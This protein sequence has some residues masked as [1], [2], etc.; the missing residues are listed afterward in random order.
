MNAEALSE[1]AQQALEAGQAQTARRLL[2][3]ALSRAPGN[4]CAG[5]MLVRLEKIG[6]ASCR[7]R[8]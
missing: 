5:L 4:L 2:T 1:V 7:E 6:R 3:F 8:V